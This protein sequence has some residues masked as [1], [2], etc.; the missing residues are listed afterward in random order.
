ML[1]LAVPY[2]SSKCPTTIGNRISICRLH[3]LGSYMSHY[4]TVT[5]AVYIIFIPTSFDIAF[6]FI[7]NL[8][9][10]LISF[11][12]INKSSV[13]EFDRVLLYHMTNDHTLVYTLYFRIFSSGHIFVN[14]SRYSHFQYLCFHQDFLVTLQLLFQ[15]PLHFI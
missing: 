1:D 14:H 6:F 8:H 7:E 4:F 5:I 10:S 12:F 2:K 3:S 13:S 15:S 11:M 9:F